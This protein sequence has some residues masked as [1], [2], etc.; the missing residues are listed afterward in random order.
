MLSRRFFWY[1]LHWVKFIVVRIFNRSRKNFYKPINFTLA[2]YLFQLSMAS[3]SATPG[4]VS[5]ITN[6]SR[7]GSLSLSRPDFKTQVTLSLVIRKFLKLHQ[8]SRC[9]CLFTNEVFCATIWTIFPISGCHQVKYVKLS[10][11][12]R[13]FSRFG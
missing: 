12:T 6:S 4:F 2:G 3:Q 1:L 10:K 5:C 7:V 13:S 8:P 11:M 9:V